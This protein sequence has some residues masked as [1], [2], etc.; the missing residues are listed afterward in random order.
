VLTSPSDVGWFLNS[1]AM[2]AVGLV[3]KIV[4]GPSGETPCPPVTVGVPSER[5]PELALL[6]AH[7]RG[8][9]E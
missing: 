8:K 7:S 6:D 5:K 9:H 4:N 3:H 2:K 1:G